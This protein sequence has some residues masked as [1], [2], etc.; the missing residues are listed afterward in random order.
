MISVYQTKF[1]GEEGNCLAAC[2]ASIFELPIEAIPDFG[3]DA[4]WFARF[5]AWMVENFGLQP[6]DLAISPLSDWRPKG[7]HLICGK[8]PRGDFEHAIVGRNGEAVHDP[9]PEGGCE[10]ETVE[11]Y[12]VFLACLESNQVGVLRKFSVPQV[13]IVS[14]W[15]L[16]GL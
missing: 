1:G 15:A 16:E 6:V 10:L 11:T 9:H 13:S 5:E 2:L 7:Y 14:V 3:E 12:T 4:L 8:S